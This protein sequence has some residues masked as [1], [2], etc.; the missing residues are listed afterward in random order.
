MQYTQQY[1]S[2]KLTWYRHK[3]L[4]IIMSPHPLPPNIP[5]LHSGV[6]HATSVCLG[7]A[8]GVIANVRACVCTYV[9]ASVCVYFCV[10]P[11]LCMSFLHF[12]SVSRSAYVVCSKWRIKLW[13]EP[14][15]SP[16][17]AASPVAT[18]GKSES[19]IPSYPWQRWILLPVHVEIE[20]Q[21]C[22]LTLRSNSSVKLPQIVRDVQTVI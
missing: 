9:C 16:P 17:T 1:P 7:S 20:K 2:I 22:N 12:L 14:S 3:P 8:G 15:R 5:F 19:W 13:T 21:A 6:C 11:Y 10:C 18:T 4:E